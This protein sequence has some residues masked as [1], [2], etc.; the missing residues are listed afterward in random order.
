MT[1]KSIHTTSPM[2]LLDNIQRVNAPDAI[3]DKIQAEINART[4][5]V[6]PM[7]YVKAIAAAVALL[8]VANVL[9]VLNWNESNTQNGLEELTPQIEYT[10]YE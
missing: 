6:V 7:F 5:N 1:K 3:W 4:E 10:L 2:K 9:L 8:L